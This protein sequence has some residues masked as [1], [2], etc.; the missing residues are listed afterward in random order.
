[1]SLKKCYDCGQQVSTKAKAC[2]NC[3]APV[4][5]SGYL[6]LLVF[7]GILFPLFYYVLSKDNQKSIKQFISF[8]GE[9]APKE[10]S[11]SDESY[12]PEWNTEFNVGISKTLASHRLPN[13]GEYTWK[14]TTNRGE[15]LV[16]CSRDGKNWVS[17]LFLLGTMR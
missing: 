2:P 13:C 4:K 10:E 3:G 16:K 12:E 9:S 8:P 5:V 17:Y 7:V 1:M 6:P 11:P 14:E 15:Y